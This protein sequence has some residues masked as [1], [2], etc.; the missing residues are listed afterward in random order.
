MSDRWPWTMVAVMGA[1]A[2]MVVLVALQMLD[3][4]SGL[5][6]LEVLGDCVERVDATTTSGC[7]AE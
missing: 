5:A 6:E 4:A 7:S 3:A 1:L 2:I